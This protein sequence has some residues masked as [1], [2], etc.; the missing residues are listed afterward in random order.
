MKWGIWCNSNGGTCNS[1]WLR[2]AGSTWIFDS[3]KEAQRMADKMNLIGGWT[4]RV[5]EYRGE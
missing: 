5:M 1:L 2:G 4:Y 3:V